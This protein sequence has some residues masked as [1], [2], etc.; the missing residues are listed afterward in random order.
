VVEFSGAAKEG[1]MTRRRYTE[2]QI[3]GILKQAEAG[4]KTAEICREHGISDATFY[5]WKA[6]YAGLT[7]SELR[8]LKALEEENRRLKHLVADLTLDNQ[9]LKE[10]TAKNW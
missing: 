8:R 5:K 10:L 4:L 3:I 1:G 9:V 6:K 2:E 7:V